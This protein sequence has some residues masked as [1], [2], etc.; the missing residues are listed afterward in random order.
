MKSKVEWISSN[1]EDYSNLFRKG[2]EDDFQRL[3]H[4][5]TLNPGKAVPADLYDRVQE[6]QGDMN[7]SKNI[8]I[9]NITPSQQ[10]LEIAKSEMKHDRKIGKGPSKKIV[11][12]YKK[13]SK[14]VKAQSTKKAS[15]GRRAKKRSS[16]QLTP[17]EKSLKRKK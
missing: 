3:N 4:Y 1:Q 9:K 8:V 10:A 14:S 6:G 11:P 15:T 7:H 13:K 17:F 2:T 12:L 16:S 5:T